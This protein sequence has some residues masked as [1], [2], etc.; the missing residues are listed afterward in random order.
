MEYPSPGEYGEFPDASGGAPIKGLVHQYHREGTTRYV[1]L[2]SYATRTIH[3]YRITR[4]GRLTAPAPIEGDEANREEVQ[5]SEVSE[6]PQLSNGW[7]RYLPILL[8]GFIVLLFAVGPLLWGTLRELRLSPMSFESF[9]AADLTPTE[10]GELVAGRVAYRRDL[11]D[12]WSAPEDVWRS[13]SGDCEDQALLVSAYLARHGVEHQLVGLALRS[14]L[15]G[16]VVVVA[17][18]EKYRLLIDPTKATAPAGVERFSPST[19]LRDILSPYAI[20]PARL[21]PSNPEPG[22]PTPVGFVE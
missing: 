22:R 2:Y 19:P 21:Y 11:D 17:E 7:L 4:K 5:H 10:V 14:G 9:M 16:H 13:R 3:T 12:Y 6:L 1:D 18:T 8:G 15:Q 20:L